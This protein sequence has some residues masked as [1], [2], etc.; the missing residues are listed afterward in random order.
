[1]NLELLLLV[2]RIILMTATMTDEDFLL[3]I[4]VTKKCSFVETRERGS[5]FA[6]ACPLSVTLFLTHSHTTFNLR[7]FSAGGIHTIS[8][9]A[10][11]GIH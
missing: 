7:Q 4:Y 6:V 3:V 9:L 1:M 10:T 2:L 5:H 8:V 11:G